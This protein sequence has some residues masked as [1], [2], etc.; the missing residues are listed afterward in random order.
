MHRSYLTVLYFIGVLT[1][2]GCVLENGS[3]DADHDGVAD[4][5]DKCPN[6]NQL[7]KLPRDFKWAGAVDPK[8]MEVGPTAYPVDENGCELDNDGDGVVNSRDYCPDDTEI[9]LSKGVAKN[10]CPTQSDFDGTPDYRDRCPDT[11]LGVKTD[12]YGCPVK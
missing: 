6:T 2:S 12:R 3:S 11:P 1:V 5:L 7:K 10:G 8:R 9:M 4:S